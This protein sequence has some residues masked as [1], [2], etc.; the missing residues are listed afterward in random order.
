MPEPEHKHKKN[1]FFQNKENSASAQEI[2]KLFDRIVKNV[3]NGVPLSE[4]S[5]EDKKQLKHILDHFDPENAKYYAGLFIDTMMTIFVCFGLICTLAW[6]CGY[7]CAMKRLTTSQ[8][9]LEDWFMGSEAIGQQV[10]A[11][12]ASIPIVNAP[13]A[14]IMVHAPGPQ[15]AANNML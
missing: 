8:K 1:R 2:A 10:N 5:E 7:I 6:Q 11:A 3:D 9:Q 14:N 12:H 4:L 15:M 13:Q